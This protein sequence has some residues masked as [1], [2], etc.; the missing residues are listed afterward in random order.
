MSEEEKNP[1]LVRKA[2]T[3]ILRRDFIRNTGFI[4]GGTILSGGIANPFGATKTSEAKE[5]EAISETTGKCK[6]EIPPPPIPEKDIKEE[7]TSDV[8]VLG[9]GIGG[10]CAA[11]SAAQGGAKTILLEKTKNIT[12]HGAWIGAVGSRLQKKKGFKIDRDEIVGEFMRW[13]AFQPDQKIITLW[14]EQSGKAMDWL[15]DMA[16]AADF[17]YDIDIDP[18]NDQ[19]TYKHYNTAHVFASK[20]HPT[21]SNSGFMQ[22]L[23]GNALKNGVDIHFETAGKQLIRGGNGRVMGVIVKTLYGYKKFNAKAVVLCT[24]GYQNNPEM[25]GKYM[26]DALNTVITWTYPKVMTGDGHQMAMWVGAAMEKGHHCP[27]LW[28]G[29]IPGTSMIPLTRQPW[30]N[31][32][33]LGERFVNEDAPFGYT[34]R[35]D[36]GQPGHMKWVVW[37]DK[38]EEE[39]HKFKGVACER[40]KLESANSRH[41]PK[42]VESLIKRGIIVKEN[43]LEELSKKMKVPHDTFIST[44]ERYN[45]LVKLGKDL[46]FGKP[47]YML[48]T[49]EKAPFYAVKSGAALVVTSSGLEINT[50]LQVLDNNRHVI[51]GLYAA[52]D[53]SGGFF[54]NDYPNILG[55]SNGRA[56]TFGRLA[57]LN[58]AAE[59]V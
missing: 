13:G 11:L 40:M 4:A 14:V 33:I 26:P 24:G 2:K 12:V 9:A 41:N 51:Q 31:V 5:I 34:A 30:L 35:A 20:R 42:E 58:A 8:V 52:G 48:T 37:D 21:T 43:T 44:V 16:D 57:G 56:F 45:E 47:G 55:A 6:F 59:K 10:L 32:N 49:I 15:L 3:G 1:K 38:W 22:M 17:T 29:G 39:A 19:H 28:D 46:D 53:V 25:L 54:A 18:R 36:M 7:I 50:K 23:K 27:M